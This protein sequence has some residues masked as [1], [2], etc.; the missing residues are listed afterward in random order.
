MTMPHLWC[1]ID[2]DAGHEKETKEYI[3]QTHDWSTISTIEQGCFKKSCYRRRQKAGG[4]PAMRAGSTKSPHGPRDF[5]GRREILK[6][7]QN[8]LDNFNGAPNPHSTSP[9][10]P[11]ELPNSR[12]SLEI[13]SNPSQ[14]VPQAVFQDAGSSGGYE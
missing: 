13:N 12:F 11:S 8:A 9:R 14:Q 1:K 7:L 6:R 10:N 5:L 3:I 4:R 2:Y